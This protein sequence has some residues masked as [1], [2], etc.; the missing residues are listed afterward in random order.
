MVGVYI[1]LQTLI[2]F[3]SLISFGMLMRAVLSWFSTGEPSK[4]GSFLYVLTEPIIMPIRALCDRFG[5]F[6]GMPFDMPFLITMLLLSMVTMF[7]QA[8]LGV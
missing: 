6:R 8:W 7:I 4:L 2:W 5:W 3:I 1:V